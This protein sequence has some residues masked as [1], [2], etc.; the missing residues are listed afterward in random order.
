MLKALNFMLPNN[1]EEWKYKFATLN[2]KY[3]IFNYTNMET[4]KFKA[5]L[6]LLLFYLWYCILI[7][8]VLLNMY[9]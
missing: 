9:Y 7:S 8:H 5:F 6:V 1:T 2:F 3:K 4:I